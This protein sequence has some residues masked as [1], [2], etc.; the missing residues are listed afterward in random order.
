M[1]YKKLQFDP[2][3]GF[4]DSSFY[5]D[6]PDSPREILQRQ[7]N[8]TRDF[9]NSI[10][11]TLNSSKEG[12]S[13]IE[14]IKSPQIEG[15]RGNNVYEQ[16]KDIKSQMNFMALE[17][18]PDGSVDENKLAVASVTNEKIKD[19]EITSEK[20]SPDAISPYA[21]DVKN[22]NGYPSDMYLPVSEAGTLSTFK[23]YMG[24]LS[25]NTLKGKTVGHIRYILSGKSVVAVNL[26]D[27]TEETVLDDTLETG[28]AFSADTNGNIYTVKYFIEESKGKISIYK[29][30]REYG[31]KTCLNTIKV[32]E[33]STEAGQYE[34]CDIVINKGFVYIGLKTRYNVS[35]RIYKL[36][37]INTED[38]VN[39]D[40]LSEIMIFE[41]DKMPFLISSG[42]DII[43]GD[44]MFKNGENTDVEILEVSVFD[45]FDS[46]FLV[47]NSY[48]Y[49]WDKNTGLPLVINDSINKNY[50]FL[51]YNNYIYKVIDKNLVRSRIF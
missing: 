8:Q 49:I 38:I 44:R 36:F 3:A 28:E 13:G 32:I 45:C 2:E 29:H 51:L 7:H 31:Q 41:T 23:N 26:I 18:I 33:H 27:G 47:Y 16:L 5:E 6:T 21:D 12:E 22:I 50:D 11:D 43:Y 34:M 25:V 15:V 24:R 10:V 1:E 30:N 14:S 17:N 4:L 20:F 37:K 9:I 48:I 19:G 42:D 46:K 39:T 40:S 35:S